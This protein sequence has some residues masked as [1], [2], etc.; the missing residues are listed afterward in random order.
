MKNLLLIRTRVIFIIMLF[1][2]MGCEKSPFFNAGE[3]TSFLIEL[4][5]F[6]ILE[7]HD[8][9]EITLHNSEENYLKVHT[10]EN[11][12]SKLNIYVED[13]KLFL[14]D[15]NKYNWSRNYDKIRIDLYTSDLSRINIRSSVSIHTQSVFKTELLS[16]VD[17]EKYSE[18]D[19]ELEVNSFSIF[20]SSDNAGMYTFKGSAASASIRPWGSCFIYADELKISRASVRHSSI[21]DVHLFVTEQLKVSMDEKGRLFYK[22]NPEVVIENQT[23]G[24]IIPAP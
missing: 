10:G 5:D 18:I 4:E 22:G 7:I 11:L 23:R 16:I 3:E 12:L 14:K 6:S 9:F 19:M 2:G 8:I 1:L 17:F 20:V 15:G 13:G 21:G 24:T